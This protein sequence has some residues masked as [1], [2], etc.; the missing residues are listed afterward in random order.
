VMCKFKDRECKFKQFDLDNVMF[1]CTLCHPFNK[2]GK[3]PYCEEI[4]TLSSYSEPKIK[5]KN[6]TLI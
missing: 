6:R 1:N 4:E 2:I 3:C 5:S